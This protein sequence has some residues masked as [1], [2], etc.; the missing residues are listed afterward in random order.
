MSEAKA[1]LKIEPSNKSCDKTK[2]SGISFATNL[3]NNSMLYI[4][5]PQNI[6]SPNTS[7]YT[8]DTAVVYISSP[9]NPPNIFEKIDLFA[10]SMSSPT[11]GCTRP[12]PFFTIFPFFESIGLFSGCA[13]IDSKFLVVFNDQYVYSSFV[14]SFF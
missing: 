6:A 2:F 13:T 4:P 7:W 8:S 1:A 14:I 9:P 12:Y 5:L 3:S 10:S 11:D